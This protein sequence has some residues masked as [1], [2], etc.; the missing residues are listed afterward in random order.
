MAAAPVI[1]VTFYMR[2]LY[3]LVTR[4]IG[5]EGTTRIYIAVF[6]AACCGRSR[7]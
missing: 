1:G 7:S 4:F 6:I 5:P 2:G 3:R